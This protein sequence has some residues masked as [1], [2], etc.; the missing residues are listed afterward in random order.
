MRTSIRSRTRTSP[1]TF[2]ERAPQIHRRTWRATGSPGNAGK[3]QGALREKRAA[4][5]HPVV[6]FGRK[7][8]AGS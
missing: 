5:L 7:P 4:L 6:E 8:V 1:C 2:H 3:P